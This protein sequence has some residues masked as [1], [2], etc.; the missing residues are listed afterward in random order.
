MLNKWFGWKTWND[1]L[2]LLGIILIPGL[3]VLNHWIPLPS[4][5]IGA[6]IVTCALLWNFY[7]RKAKPDDVPPPPN[8]SAPPVP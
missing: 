7:F 6:T 3:W 1:R 5:V 2:S 4:E 8:P